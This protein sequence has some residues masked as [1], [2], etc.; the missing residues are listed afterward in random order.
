MKR[1]IAATPTAP[2]NMRT[3]CINPESVAALVTLAKAPASSPSKTILLTKPTYE[4]ASP[5]ASRS[6]TILKLLPAHELSRCAKIQQPTETIV[7]P[8]ARVKREVVW[9]TITA[10]SHTTANIGSAT[11][12]SA[13]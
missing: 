5:T 2:P 8:S 6:S 10:T 9:I 12:A 13:W 7:S 11:H 1:V 4:H 3:K